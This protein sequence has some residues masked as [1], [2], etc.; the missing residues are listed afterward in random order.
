M[1]LVRSEKVISQ[2]L[3]GQHETNHKQRNAAINSQY[4]MPGKRE[5]GC[6]RVRGWLAAWVYQMFSPV[7]GFQV[8]GRLRK[9]SETRTMWSFV[10]WTQALFN[11]VQ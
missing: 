1:V 3:P 7:N 6:V 8:A 4:K 5:W 9:P 2:V 11:H 10:M